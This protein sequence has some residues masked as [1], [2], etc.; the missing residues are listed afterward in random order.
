MSSDLIMV[1][2]LSVA[3]LVPLV[4]GVALVIAIIRHLN[5]R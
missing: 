2:M 1:I 4:S 5:K 3:L